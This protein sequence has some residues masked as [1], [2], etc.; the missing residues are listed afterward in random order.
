VQRGFDDRDLV[1]SFDQPIRTPR[2]HHLRRLCSCHVTTDL[3]VI[4][5]Q[6]REGGYRT[7]CQITARGPVAASP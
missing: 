4:R 2:I 6:P 7:Q 1:R 5:P 3:I